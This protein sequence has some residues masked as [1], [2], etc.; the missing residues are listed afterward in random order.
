MKATIT[1][2]T[3]KSIAPVTYLDCAGVICYNDYI[4]LKAITINISGQFRFNYSAIIQNYSALLELYHGITM[5][6]K[7][8]IMKISRLW[9]SPTW[10]TFATAVGVECS[11]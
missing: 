2:S 4:I 6:K 10:S 8:F 3:T 11:F 1:T 9:S 7:T 5:S